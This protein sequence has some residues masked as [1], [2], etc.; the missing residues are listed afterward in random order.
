V[1]FP[2]S[3]GAKTPLFLVHLPSGVGDRH[4]DAI[5]LGNN[6]VL[7]Q[8]L[9]DFSIMVMNQRAISG[10]GASQFLKVIGK[11]LRNENRSIQPLPPGI[12]QARLRD[13]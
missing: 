8:S 6:A 9:P 13:F 3:H 12:F 2:R 1:F 5:A 10:E 7:I 4:F 11:E